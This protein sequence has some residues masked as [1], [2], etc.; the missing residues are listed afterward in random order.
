M[1]KPESVLKNETHKILW[2]FE[3][4]TDHFDF[5]SADRRMKIKENKKRDKYLDLSRELRKL[6]NMNMGQGNGP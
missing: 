5:H 4:K 1:H 3:I 2:D 6:L